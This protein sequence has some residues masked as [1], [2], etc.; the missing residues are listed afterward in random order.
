MLFYDIGYAQTLTMFLTVQTSY[1]F[2]DIK[3]NHWNL[4][5]KVEFCLNPVVNVINLIFS[6]SCSNVCDKC[7]SL[8]ILFLFFHNVDTHG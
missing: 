4:K 8:A 2:P 5:K 7:P 1:S 6:R 3:Q